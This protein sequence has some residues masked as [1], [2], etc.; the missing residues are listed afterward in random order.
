MGRFAR[1]SRE[2]VRARSFCRVAGFIEAWIRKS[3]HADRP[4]RPRDV[5][6]ERPGVCTGDLR[7]PFERAGEYC[8]CLLTSNISTGEHEC[9]YP[10]SLQGQA[11]EL[12]VTD[13]LVAR[14]H[15]P[16]VPACFSEPDFVRSAFGETVGE[17]LDGR[18]RVAQG[19]YNGKA[20]ERLVD[21]ERNRFKRP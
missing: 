21:K 10:G 2:M 6:D 20:V 11:F 19:A 13:T 16:A 8:T 15:D 12:A 4:A 5:I 3:I 1:S 14:Q 17:A 7:Y 18:S 9:P